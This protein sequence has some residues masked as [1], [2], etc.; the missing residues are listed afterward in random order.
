[1]LGRLGVTRVRFFLPYPHPHEGTARA[2]AGER[3]AAHAPDPDSAS[4]VL[5]SPLPPALKAGT[6]QELRMRERK[7]R[8][9]RTQR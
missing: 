9:L 7:R 6:Q 1:M 8:K 5:A 2:G 3:P 4:G